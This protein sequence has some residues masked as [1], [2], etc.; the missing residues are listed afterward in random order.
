MVS[1]GRRGRLGSEPRSHLL[2]NRW[3]KDN[4]RRLRVGRCVTTQPSGCPSPERAATGVTLIRLVVCPSCRQTARLS[5]IALQDPV[6][7]GRVGRIHKAGTTLVETRIAAFS[8]ASSILAASTT[9]CH[10]LAD[11][12]CGLYSSRSGRSDDSQAGSFVTAD[13]GQQN[14]ENPG[15]TRVDTSASIVLVDYYYY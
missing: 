14:P 1:T 7:G 13:E 5:G 2:V 11:R 8:D 12:L 4:C 15:L 6:P 10:S 9:T 3:T